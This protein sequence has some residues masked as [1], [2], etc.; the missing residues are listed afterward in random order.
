[1]EREERSVQEY[2]AIDIMHILSYVWKHAWA[3]VL[4][5][6]LAALIGLVTALFIM[7]PVYSAEVRLYVEV[8]AG[9]V[10]SSN[11]TA[12]RSLVKTCGTILSGRSTLDRVIE[13]AGLDCDW[14]DLNR[15]IVCE[16]SGDTEILRIQVSCDDPYLASDIANTIAEVL[17]ERVE[18]I[19]AGTSMKLVDA[20]KP[21]PE[22]VG[23]SGLKYTVVGGLLGALLIV[24][25]LVV[26]ALLDDTIHD[27]EY[28]TRT[29][30]YPILG[31][32]P[33]LLSSGGRSYGYY[34]RSE[35]TDRGKGA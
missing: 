12:A 5:G 22:K 18:E 11:L 27:E 35:E 1:M 34:T 23:P 33:D 31:K 19:V 10:S 20:A 3:V 24:A 9:G 28:V 29:Y 2:Y 14:K 17:P 32:V 13:Q 25:V 16:A 21:N 26:L 4:S 8:N 6:V 15:M 7:K 30:N